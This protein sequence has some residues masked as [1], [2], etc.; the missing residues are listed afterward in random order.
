MLAATRHEKTRQG[1]KLAGPRGVASL[2]RCFLF[3]PVGFIIEGCS[4]V[5]FLTFSVS[6]FFARHVPWIVVKL[7]WRHF[8]RSYLVGVFVVA[9]LGLLK[10]LSNNGSPFFQFH[11]FIFSCVTDR[12]GD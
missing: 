12:L 10:N 7:S 6:D 2:L 5:I 3:L 9:H 11:I 8:T 1:V 4:N